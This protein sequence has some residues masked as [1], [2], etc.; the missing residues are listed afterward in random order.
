MVR[1]V[2]LGVFGVMFA[3]IVFAVMFSVVMFA[4]IVFGVI[5]FGVMFAVVMFGMMFA[6]AVHPVEDVDRTRVRAY[7]R[8][9]AEQRDDHDR[10]CQESE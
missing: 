3:V 10:G 8:D 6:V 5:V 7:D 9:A 4:V 1:S 2:V